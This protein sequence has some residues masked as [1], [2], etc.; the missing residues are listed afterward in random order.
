M[1]RGMISKFEKIM[2]GLIGILFAIVLLNNLI[3]QYLDYGFKVEFA[4]PNIVLFLGGIGLL[5]AW[6]R[7]GKR[8]VIKSQKSK[9]NRKLQ[10]LILI[11]IIAILCVAIWWVVMQL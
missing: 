3:F 11:E 5:G 1:W 8:K 7:F 4:L 2:V 10:I 9:D 6:I